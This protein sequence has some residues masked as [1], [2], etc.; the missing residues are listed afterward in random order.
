MA[1]YLVTN[2]SYSSYNYDK[3]STLTSFSGTG[4]TGRVGGGYSSPSS[5]FGFIGIADYSGIDDRH[6]GTF[7]YAS[8]EASAVWRR[9]LGSR[10]EIRA[11]G[12]LFYKET[13]VAVS[14]A[15]SLT[16]MQYKNGSVLGPHVG[17]EYWY[18]VTPK[19]GLQVSLN[20]YE[21][22]LSISS[23]NGQGIDPS[24]SYQLGVAGSYRVTNHFTGLLG[25]TRR[26]DAYKFKST[27]GST[28]ST[29]ISG[30]YIHLLAEYNF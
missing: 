26:D 18:S 27:V 6:S 1:A 21:G 14:D 10:G 2:V 11:T 5:E 24:F 30:T 13:P 17:G 28:N 8:A 12:G 22:F 3:K 20:L 29:A 15:S 7:T 23:P 9:K 19:L 16:V 25:L 4:G